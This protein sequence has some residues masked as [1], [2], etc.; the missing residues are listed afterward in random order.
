MPISLTFQEVIAFF[1]I[2]GLGGVSRELVTHPHITDWKNSW[3]RFCYQIGS[4]LIIGG[5]IGI[6]V[7]NTLIISGLAGYS[8]SDV[9]EELIKKKTY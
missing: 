9:L 5:F 3:K 6:L 8:G 7:D 2:G 4:A 1:L